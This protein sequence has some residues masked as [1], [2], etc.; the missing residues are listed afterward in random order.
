MNAQTSRT[1][2]ATMLGSGVT[3][4]PAMEWFGG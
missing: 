1:A 2:I 3:A 4:T